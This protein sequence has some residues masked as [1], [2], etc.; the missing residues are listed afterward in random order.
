M[1]TLL[2]HTG[3]VRASNLGHSS[4]DEPMLDDSD[5][6]Y[7][8]MEEDDDEGSTSGQASI[9]RSLQLESDSRDSPNSSLTSASVASSIPDQNAKITLK[10]EAKPENINNVSPYMFLKA[11][12][13]CRAKSSI[14]SRLS[15]SEYASQCV[16]AAEASR[17]NPY[18]LHEDEHKLLQ[19]KLCYSHVSVYLNIRNGILRLWTRNPSVSVNLEEAIGCTRDE[20]W[21]RLACFA[22]EWL[23]RR[24]YINFGCVEPPAITK[25]VGR[26]RKKETSQ[27]TIVVIGGG[28]AG[29]STARQLTNLFRHYPDRAPPKIIV[30][31]GR[32]RIGGRIYSHPLTSMRSAKLSPDQRP[33]VE[34]GAH[35]IVGFEHGNPLDAIV[36]GQLALDYHLLRDLSTLYDVDGTPVNG[37]NDAMI[38]RLYNDVLDRTGHYRLKNTVKKTAQGDKDM[39]DVGRDPPDEDGLTIKEFE[40]ATALGTID[41]LLPS[42]KSRRR[43]A[44]HRAGKSDKSSEEVET[45]TETKTQ[46]PAA[47]AAKEFGFL[48]RKTTQMH[49]TLEFDDLARQLN[50]SLGTVMNSGI[51]Q[52]QKFLD[53]KPYALRLINWHFANLEYANAANV[54]KLSLRGWDQDIGNEFEGEHAQVVGGYQQVPRALWRHPEPL[55]V[56]TRKAVKS[57]RYSAAG[58]QGKATITCEDGQSIE[59]DKVVFAAP[60]GILKEQSIQFDPPLPQWKRDAIRRMGFGLLNKVILVFER[61]F[62]DVERDMFGLLRPPRTGNGNNQS[63]YKE[64]RGQFYLF[65]NCIE[66]SGLPVLIALMAGESAHEAERVPDEVIVGQCVEQ[67]RNVFGSMNVP[68]PVES[69]VTRWGSD[70]FARGTYSYVA[71]EARPG[72]YDLIASP[73]QN[74]FF[75]G[76]ATIATHPA[77][78][79]G[80]Y[81][82]GL[83]AANEVFESLVGG[84]PIPPTLVPAPTLKKGSAATIDLTQMD[85][86]MAIG[87]KRKGDELLPAGTFTRPVKEKDNSLNEAWDAAMWVRIYDDLGPPPVKPSKANVNSFLLYSGEH[88]EEVKTRLGDERKKAGKKGKQS[89]R[90]QVRVELGKMWAALTEE[91]RKPYTDQTNK[92]R[93]ENEKALKEWAAKAAEWDKRT[94]EVKDVWIKEGNSFE[95]FCKRKSDED[96]MMDAADMAKRAKI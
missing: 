34:M 27:E 81:L 72:D 70:R 37:V 94:W 25:S 17:L 40:E 49:E 55:D 13:T 86:H 74:L 50:Q 45:S 82:S 11:P 87:G 71:A 19:D 53:L 22:Y 3:A 90:D 2:A 46:L 23:L 20:R 5:D 39:I 8:K 85:T 33:T 16:A 92:N 78:V 28:M 47:Q 80:A 93:E 26:G 67:L 62:W 88:W 73:I 54:D 96:A 24:G 21:T 79:H 56:R 30:L 83:R 15:P 35:I 60:L 58:S 44:G 29:L 84:I 61:P 1:S 69:I 95:E 14:P 9:L 43:G 65:W 4:H 64:G 6:S 10:V 63:D 77:T 76:E 18:A 31:E 59:A 48:L 57:I 52:Y 91:E 75:A 7:I 51:D 32:D 12:T 68:P 66:T 36:R 89:E 42:K 38:E 41:Q